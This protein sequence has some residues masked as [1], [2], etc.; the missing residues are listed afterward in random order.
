MARMTAA[1]AAV[2][3]LRREGVSNVFGLP[4]FVMGIGNRWA[5]RHTA[6]VALLD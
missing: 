3:I 1:D 4:D 6:V 2:A 5:N